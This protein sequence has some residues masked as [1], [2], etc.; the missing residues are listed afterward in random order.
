M[1]RIILKIGVDY[2]SDPEQVRDL[3]LECAKSHPQVVDVPPPRALLLNFGDSALE[4]ELRCVVKDFDWSLVVKSDLY[5]AILKGLRAAGIRIPAPQRE[6]RVVGDG[7][8]PLA[9]A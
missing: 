7:A 8:A 9:G 4:F 5:F 1:G 3:L 2:A 6:V